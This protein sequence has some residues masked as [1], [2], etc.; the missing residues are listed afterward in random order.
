MKKTILAV[1]VAM[2]A[3]AGCKTG[4]N[5]SGAS[6]DS[7][8]VRVAS[9]QVAFVRL[10]SLVSGYDFYRELQT[11][12]EE[13][14]KK[15]ENELTS[16]GRSL[17]RDIASFE[18]KIEKGLVTRAQAAEMQEQLQRRQ[19]SFMQNRENLMREMAEEEQVMLNN[20]HYNIVEYLKEFNAD[21]RFGMILSTNAG[22]P[23]LNA[24]P[25]L[26]IT[27]EVLAG[28][29]KKYTAEKSKSKAAE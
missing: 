23:I 22:G 8:T 28:L 26:D 12:Y 5:G 15:V 14:A 25:V 21:Y 6:A 9:S 7:T 17:E 4:G 10:D 29:N 19:Q 18:E 13:K 2:F 16:K 11:N 1:L 3:M 24:D 20:I 27:T